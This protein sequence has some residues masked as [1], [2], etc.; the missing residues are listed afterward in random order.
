MG[1]IIFLWT[2]A[3]LFHVAWQ[4][5]FEPWVADPLNVRPIAHAIWDPHFGQPAIEAFTRGGADG[6]VNI[7]FSGVY[8]WWFTIGMRTNTDLYQGAVFLILVAALLLF[9]GWL[10]LQPSFRPSVSWFKNAESRLNHHLSGLF[11]VSSLAWIGHLVHVA[12]PESRGVHVRWNNLL[13]SVTWGGDIVEVRGKVAMMPIS[14]GTADFMVHHIHAFTIHVTA[15]ILLKGVLFSRSSRLIPDKANLGFRFPC[16]G[17][18]RGGTCQVSAW[19]H[20]FLGLFW[21][22]NCISV[23]LFHFSWKMQSDVWGT[24][25]AAGK[26]THITGGNFA[27]SAV[28]VNGWLRDFLWSQASQVIQSYGSAASAYGLIF[29]GA[30]FIWA[31]SLMFLFSGRGYWP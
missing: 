9:G 21:M 19:D 31:F 5:N 12:I 22:Y 6:P 23:V 30:H 17:P 24:I 10:H 18:G 8:Q 16:D 28:S 27:N 15:L 4:G 20:V 14:L 7:A 13:T 11:G 29:L 3:N 2:S 26:I 25:S 1:A